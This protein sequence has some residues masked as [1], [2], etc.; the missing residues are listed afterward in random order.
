[1]KLLIIIL[2]L[3]FQESASTCESSV[4]YTREVQ[5]ITNKM[6]YSK[7]KLITSLYKSIEYQDDIFV[8]KSVKIFLEEMTNMVNKLQTNVTKIISDILI[9]DCYDE[10]AS[11]TGLV[12]P[13]YTKPSIEI[14]KNYV[15][16][17]VYY[18]LCILLLLAIECIYIIILYKLTN[19][20]IRIM[21]FITILNV[22]LTYIFYNL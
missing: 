8:N 14:Q 7:N 4:E 21:L 18:S 13:V 16:I 15:P 9:N 6:N 17:L 2:L 11:V 5:F 12:A 10:T 22:S 20:N 1:M 19:G 3:L